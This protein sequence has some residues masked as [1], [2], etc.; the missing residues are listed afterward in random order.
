[1]SAAQ[2]LEAHM[3]ITRTEQAI[4]EFELLGE[5]GDHGCDD[6]RLAWLAAALSAAGNQGYDFDA[7]WDDR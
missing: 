1:M 2:R 6:I 3:G 4:D 5:D 7:L